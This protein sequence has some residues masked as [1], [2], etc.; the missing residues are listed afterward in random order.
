MRAYSSSDQCNLGA[1]QLV[2]SF[3]SKEENELGMFEN[4]LK[5]KVKQTR[6]RPGVAQRVPG[7]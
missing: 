7:S 1:I 4:K 3:T 5:K 2:S 6:Y